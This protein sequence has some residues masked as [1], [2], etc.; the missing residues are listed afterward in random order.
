MTHIQ[1]RRD[2]SA[3]WTMNNPILFDGESGHERD[4]G[5]EKMGDGVTPWN[6]LPY[7]YGVDSVAGRTGEVTLGIGDV[8]GAAPLV[9]PQ[10][11]GSPTAPTPSTGDDD[12]SIATTAFVKAQG[13]AV[14]DSPQFTGNPT[15]PT[16]AVTDD[17]TSIATTEFVKDVLA[18]APIAPIDLGGAPGWISA[19]NIVKNLGVVTLVVDVTR[20]SLSGIGS[21]NT[22][23]ITAPPGYRPQKNLYIIGID[24]ASGGSCAMYL[25]TAGAVQF[26]FGRA[27][28][29]SSLGYFTFVAVN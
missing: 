13:Y 18:Q 10:F 24:S 29:S 15:A 9:S 7:K 22:P 25:T 12:T 11:T 3:I 17:D 2:E 6:D 27:A 16:P 23:V 20:D 26:V 4:T 1:Q 28:G 19:S 21:A 14:E 8:A 5:R